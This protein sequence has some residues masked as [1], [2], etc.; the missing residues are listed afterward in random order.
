M[1]GRSKSQIIENILSIEQNLFLLVNQ[2]CINDL[3]DNISYLIEN[4]VD[5]SNKKIELDSKD[6]I[7]FNQLIDII[8]LGQDVISWVDLSL[9]HTNIEETIIQVTLVKVGKDGVPI[10]YHCAIPLPINHDGYTKFDIN[11]INKK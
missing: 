6:K 8:Y 10:D 2:N 11:L 3:S 7:T 4:I 5:Y 1:K 9:F